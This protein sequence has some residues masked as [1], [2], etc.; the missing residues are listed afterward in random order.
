MTTATQQ[1]PRPARRPDPG[2]PR[3]DWPRPRLI[4]D[5][6]A[7]FMEPAYLDGQPYA[8]GDD[9]EDEESEG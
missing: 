8:T 3:T 9:L 4:H 5:H 1:I 6:T 2:R 7:L